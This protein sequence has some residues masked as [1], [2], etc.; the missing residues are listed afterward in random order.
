MQT[1]YSDSIFTEFGYLLPANL[2]NEL[3]NPLKTY[4]PIPHIID[5]L[6]RKNKN[7]L[8]LLNSFSDQI[9]QALLQSIALYLVENFN[10]NTSLTH[11][12]IYFDTTKLLRYPKPHAKIA[13]D[14]YIKNQELTNT[15]KRIIVAINQ[16]T[17]SHSDFLQEL[18]KIIFPLLNHPNWRFILFTAN[19]KFQEYSYLKSFFHSLSLAEP[20]EKQILAIFNILKKEIENYHAVQI[21]EDNL[22]FIYSIAARYISGQQHSFDKALELLDSSAA[23][24]SHSKQESSAEQ[25]P[26]VTET[27]V[28]QVA[29]DWTAIPISHFEKNR[30][31]INEF[32]TAMQQKIYGQESAINLLSLV[33]QHANINLQ[34]RSHAMCGFIFTGPPNVGKTETAL[35]LAEL[36]CGHKQAFFKINID[37]INTPASLAEITVMTHPTDNQCLSLFAAIQ[38]YPTCILYI[39][40]IPRAQVTLDL[41]EELL[42]LG[43]ALDTQG[44]KYDFRHALL[45][46]ATT[47]GAEQIISLLQPDHAMEQNQSV[48]LMQLVLNPTNNSM[49][50]Q[51]SEHFSAQELCSAVMPALEHFF[52]PSLLRQLNIIP[53]ISLNYSA[54][55]KI[56]RGKL[57][58]LTQQLDAQFNIELNYETEVIRFLVHQAGH[59]ETSRSIDKLLEQHLYACIA[60]EIV[61]HAENKTRSKRLCIRLNDS[62]QLLQ[63]EFITAHDGVLYHRV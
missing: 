44:N 50:F 10:P 4:P 17:S 21:P 30:F 23:R 38:Q 8:I 61:V 18:E 31:K 39:E 56:I 62:G 36:L 46:I 29:S 57:Q 37:K 6:N 14:F 51:A 5:V 54:S 13:E 52:N 11:E 47:V 9:N 42:T 53:F 26:I 48:D 24:A 35:A 34:K 40:N 60:H 32:V 33:L 19:K 15:N 28:A 55:E 49:P 2:N 22:A 16:M 63:C 1:N 45:I 43:Y 41:F 59:R 7:H 12:V 25:K 27:I 3:A 58:A 20:T